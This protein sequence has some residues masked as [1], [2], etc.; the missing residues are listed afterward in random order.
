M[1]LK[2]DTILIT[3]GTSGI[4]L[5]MAKQ[6]MARGNNVIIT[7]R[8][9]SKLEATKKKFPDLHIY[10]SDVSDPQSICELYSKVTAD[11]PKLNMIINNAGIMRAIDFNNTE[12]DNI[13]DEIDINLNGPIRMAQQFL[14][15]LKKQPEAAIVNVSSGLAF[16]TFPKAPIYSTSKIGIHAYTKSLRLQLKDTSVKVF[17]LAPPKTSKPLFSRSSPEADHKNNMPTMDVPDVVKVMIDSIMK[18][19]FEI[20]PGMSK[21]LKLAGRFKL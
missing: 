11:F 12:Y 16:I 13:C 18:N 19:K 8:D 15:H 6:L 5:E 10:Q 7:G 4:G 3:G 21:L 1:N 14:H 2:S 17:E 9:I 20:L